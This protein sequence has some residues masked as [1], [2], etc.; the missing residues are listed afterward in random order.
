MRQG[1]VVGLTFRHPELTFDL[2]F[3]RW[4]LGEV[5]GLDPLRDEA[6]RGVA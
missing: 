1:R 6:V 4:F 2:R 3:H 5:A